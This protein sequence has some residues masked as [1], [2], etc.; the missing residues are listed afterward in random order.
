MPVRNGETKDH[1]KVFPDNVLMVGV[2]RLEGGPT[3][4]T[5]RPIKEV[6]LSRLDELNM[7]DEMN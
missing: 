6:L 3:C 4:R 7:D 2:W 5:C 1:L